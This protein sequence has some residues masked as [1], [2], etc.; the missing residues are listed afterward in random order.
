VGWATFLQILV[1]LG[2]FVLDLS[3]KTCQTYMSRGLATL[4][5][6]LEVKALVAD[7]GLR[8]PSVHRVLT[9]LAFSFGRYWAF[10]VRAVTGLVTLI[11]YFFDL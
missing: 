10:T 2:C 4:T 9:S 1:L 11:F 3:A 8:A 7:A 6:T 5:L